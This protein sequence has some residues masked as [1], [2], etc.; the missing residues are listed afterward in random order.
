MLDWRIIQGGMGAYI[1]HPF[2][3]K[4]VS[5]VSKGSALGTI[6]GIAADRIL[7][8]IL[9]KGDPGGHYRRAL[10]HFPFQEAVKDIVDY[11]FVEG[12]IPEGAEYKT[13][14]PLSFK[15][16]WRT[17]NLFVCA[18]F[19]FVWLAKE[20]HDYPISIN[21]LEKI[22]MPHVYSLAGAMIAGVDCVTMGAGIPTQI[23]GVMDALSRGEDAIYKVSVTNAIGGHKAILF[24]FG[25]HFGADLGT[26]K[27]PVFLPIISSNLMAKIMLTRS[28]GSIEGFVIETPTAGG[29]N[30]PPREKHS[31]EYGGKDR[32]D[33][34]KIVELGLP[35]WIGGSYASPAGLAEAIS[36]GA[37]G[38]QV[39]SIFALSQQSG[40]KD[41]L[42][43]EIRRRGFLKATGVDTNFSIRTDF[44]VSPT[45]FP[46]KVVE[47]PG[48]LSDS[49]V[50]DNRTRYCALRYLATPVEKD[51]K[52]IYLC[53]S[54]DV[55]QYVRKGGKI[56]DTVGRACLC[57]GL[58]ATA[59]LGTP[60]EPEIATLGDDVNFLE[61]L[62]GGP[63]D[64]YTVADVIGYLLS[65]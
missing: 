61:H 8:R 21:Y 64:T 38:I 55:D 17:I 7:S 19:A 34:E 12:G 5:L 31:E 59:D 56:E 26:L 13:V 45:G 25:K 60:G 62:M 43:R 50:Y 1:S 54:E 41:S 58:L 63:D 27:R 47:L 10:A 57:Q 53:A 18:S 40:M 51:G 30:A 14:I 52:I 32:V 39:G 36:A 6:S 22:Q 49:A 46:F 16:S 44:R 4:E 24:N 23:P 2:L 11:Y 65:A 15:P 48:T 29:H 33:F 37:K 3:A 35:F 20:G 28:S 9:Q 42:R